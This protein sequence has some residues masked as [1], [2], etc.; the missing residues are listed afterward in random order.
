ML[1]AT[2]AYRGSKRFECERHAQASAQ[3]RLYIYQIHVSQC[4]A[5]CTTVVA[6]QPR[7]R[8]GQEKNGTGSI[9]Y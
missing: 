1:P 8:K 6:H 3:A 9:S 4:G 7:A 5:R 2:D